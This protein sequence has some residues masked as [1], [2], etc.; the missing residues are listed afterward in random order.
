[1]T[2]SRVGKFLCETTGAARFAEAQARRQRDVV[3]LTSE[4]A[5]PFL[6]RSAVA[7]TLRCFFGKTVVVPVPGTSLRPEVVNQV[8]E[9]AEAY[10][11][12]DRLSFAADGSDEGLVLGLGCSCDGTFVD[13]HGWSV[14]VNEVGAQRLTPTAPAAAFAAAAGVAK[15]F[16]A[17]IGRDSL[18]VNEAWTAPLLDLPAGDQTS[19]VAHIDFGR[20]MVIGAGAIGAGL[21]H[22]LRSSGWRGE[23]L[24]IDNQ[25]YDEPNHET[26]LLISKANALRQRPKAATL[27]GLCESGAIS[28]RGVEELIVA[29][30]PLLAEPAAALVCAVDNV[31]ARR[32]LDRTA[33]A[34]VFNAG[35]GGTR[36][37]AG[38]VLWSRHD[39]K[40]PPLSTLYR[41]T[42]E[43]R[44]ANDG[45][46][47]DI[48][49]DACSRIAY[50]SVSL[51]APFMGLAAG[52]LL[53]AG[54][55]QH[56]LG[57]PAPTNYL[58]VDLL[59]LQ[60]RATRR[61][62]SRAGGRAA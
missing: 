54:L 27:A 31:D 5:D 42:P 23:V 58:K 34:V 19:A 6:V 57:A 12:T 25:R 35:V 21:G 3:L 1:M 50:E 62:M 9:E 2:A 14:S 13:A 41:A 48:V 61:V 20:V 59:G 45:G 15:L 4:R 11:A 26:T 52:A 49:T 55:A 39:P 17:I 22:V 18:V 8:E 47:S 28:A 24:Y 40:S 46:P 10:G 7:L 33:A 29:D 37:D 51:A 32:L 38:H 60:H 36:Y 53:A 16:A 30:H 43:S 44:V 56:A